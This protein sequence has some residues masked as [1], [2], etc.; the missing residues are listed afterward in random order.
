MPESYS[1]KI[2]LAIVKYDQEVKA[3]LEYIHFHYGIEKD[4]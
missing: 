3:T 2:R 1:G 4:T